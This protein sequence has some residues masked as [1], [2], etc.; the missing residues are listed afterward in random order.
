MHIRQVFATTCGLVI[1]LASGMSGRL[2]L[3]R[4]RANGPNLSVSPRGARSSDCATPLRAR[5]VD[6]RKATSR[7]NSEPED[8]TDAADAR[9]LAESSAQL[10]RTGVPEE[11]TRELLQNPKWGPDAL[12]KALPTWQNRL[13]A[14]MDLVCDEFPCLLV[15][16][17]SESE[18]L[19]DLSGFEVETREAQMLDETGNLPDGPPY[20]FS[21]WGYD[22]VGIAPAQAHGPDVQTRFF[23][24]VD[25]ELARRGVPE[26]IERV[27]Q[28]DPNTDLGEVDEP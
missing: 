17:T 23:W 15:I 3:L 5:S 9:E 11:W 26:A 8:G 16:E 19:S 28:T 27:L 13:D 18:T 22:V 6:R 14:P 4:L 7:K 12:W 24:R 21:G 25:V 20:A 1:G 2:V 10:Y